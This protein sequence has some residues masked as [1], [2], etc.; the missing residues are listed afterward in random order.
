[1]ITYESDLLLIENLTSETSMLVADFLL[2]NQGRNVRVSFGD[3]A[4]CPHFIVPVFALIDFYRAKGM[5]I[6][7]DVPAHSKIERALVERDGDWGFGRVCRFGST[8]EYIAIFNEVQREVLK[9]PNI[10]KG[11]KTAFGWCI[12]E[13]MDNVLQHSEANA[14]YV[15]VQYLPDERLLKTCVFDLGKG[16]TASFRGSKFAPVDA[17]EAVK[18]AVEPNVTSGNGQGNGLYGLREIVKQSKKGRLQISSDGAK[19]VLVSGTPPKEET[20]FANVL[21]GFS[22]TT[23]VDFQVVFEDPLSIDSVFGDAQPSVDLWLEDHELDENTVSVRVLEIVP[24][25]VSREFGR[26]MRQAVE[27]LIENERKR[28]IIDFSDVEMCSS[29]FVDELIGKLLVKYQFVDFSRLIGFRSLG[30]LTALLINHSIKQRLSGDLSFS[31]EAKD[32]TGGEGGPTGPTFVPR[33]CVSEQ[34]P[35]DH[36]PTVVEAMP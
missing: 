33:I 8:D 6:D 9:L 28:V 20:A 4:C 12:S 26:E 24:G 34:I 1:M 15:M 3:S 11:F 10:G 5:K 22:G 17:K 2:A 29:A 32:S 21:P 18:L 35:I 23:L 25:T 16:I 19:F 27:N 30:G 7:V 31:F 13:I 36:Q 14:G